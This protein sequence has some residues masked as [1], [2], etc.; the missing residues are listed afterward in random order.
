MP[1]AGSGL[2]R[3]AQGAESP[4][5]PSSASTWQRT[6]SPDQRLGIGRLDLD[7]QASIGDKTLEKR[8]ILTRVNTVRALRFAILRQPLF[9]SGL[10][11]FA[12]PSGT[13]AHRS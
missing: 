13:A 6:L 2:P 11:E 1:I 10:R 5:P 4:A 7:Y 8:R 9:R 3:S 12:E